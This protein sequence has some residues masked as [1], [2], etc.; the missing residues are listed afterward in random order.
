MLPCEVVVPQLTLGGIVIETW[1]LAVLIGAA[2]VLVAVFILKETIGKPKDPAQAMATQRDRSRVWASKPDVKD[3]IIRDYDP[4]RQRIGYLGR[5]LLALPPLRSMLVLA[6]SGAGKTPRIVVPQILC[7]AGPCVT[8]SVKADVLH[9]TLK[10]RQEMGTVHVID[11]SGA[12]GLT[13]SRWSPLMGVTD[14]G[15]ASRAA[16]WLCESS[17]SG[18]GSGIEG[19]AYWDSLGRRMLACLLWAAASSKLGMAQV[20]RWAQ[21][22]NEER[23][24]ALLEEAGDPRAVDMWSA[25]RQQEGRTKTSVSNTAWTVLEDW[26]H[27]DITAIVDENDSDRPV[28]DLDEVLSSASTLYLVAPA[29]EQA[30]FTPIFETIINA[31]VMRVEELAAK[32]GGLALDPPLLLALDEA[33]NIAPVREL[34]K[35]A[36]KSAGEGIVVLSIWQDEG[37]INRIYGAD[38]ART[39]M[40]NHYGKLYMPGITDD[41]TLSNLSKM[42]GHDT[43]NRVTHQ[44]HGNSW[45]A[46]DIEVAPPSYLRSLPRDEAIVISG[47]HKPMRVS[48]PGWWEDN[49]LTALIDPAVVQQY[50]TRHTPAKGRRKQRV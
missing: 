3:L 18:D 13:S 44:Q 10:R 45:T 28:L 8:G 4:R 20:A 19:A 30:M 21:S 15:S 29:S 49:T 11:P 31:F 6:P 48:L 32:N 16:K 39:V 37:Q 43:V 40:S 42:I 50:N 9:L 36:S 23:V 33:A 17:K 14:F 12:S 38:R 46:T 34:D 41:Q 24:A 27:P 25:H 7:H 1:Q 26:T 35:V 22:G 2:A 47:H 5:D